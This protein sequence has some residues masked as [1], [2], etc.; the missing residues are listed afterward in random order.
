MVL[1]IDFLSED[2]FEWRPVYEEALVQINRLASEIPVMGPITYISRES[3][4]L[5]TDATKVRVR[6]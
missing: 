3:I 2:R 5:Y 4:F 1:L 6:L